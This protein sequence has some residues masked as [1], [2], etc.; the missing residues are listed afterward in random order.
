MVSIRFKILLN[1]RLNKR[2]TASMNMIESFVIFCFYINSL[3]YFYFIYVL[4]ILKELI[5]HEN[6]TVIESL[7]LIY[8]N[9]SKKDNS[10]YFPRKFSVDLSL[11]GG[12]FSVVEFE[13]I[14]RNDESHPIGSSDIY[15]LERKSG[16]A[17]KQLII[18]RDIEVND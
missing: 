12:E 8:E 15:T 3:A 18:A 14:R 16:K 4:F 9:E 2:T 10:L 13:I 1:V 11:L 6:S 5:E 17:T 7:H